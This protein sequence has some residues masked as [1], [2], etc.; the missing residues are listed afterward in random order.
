MTVICP[1]VR[2]LQ[3]YSDLNNRVKGI[4]HSVT[5][6][7]NILLNALGGT[8]LVVLWWKKHEKCPHDDMYG[9]KSLILMACSAVR[10]ESV[11][12]DDIMAHVCLQVAV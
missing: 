1:S 12:H 7:E 8:N 6:K 11:S 5:T 4:V 9:G 3:F 10:C 2:R